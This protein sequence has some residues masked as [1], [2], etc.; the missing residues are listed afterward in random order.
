MPKIDMRDNISNIYEL[1]NEVENVP[2]GVIGNLCILI[3]CAYGAVD[4]VLSAFCC[5][6]FFGLA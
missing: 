1:K 4:R 5:V 6:Y 2:C 3:L